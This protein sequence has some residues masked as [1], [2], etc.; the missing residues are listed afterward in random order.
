[1]TFMAGCVASSCGGMRIAMKITYAMRTHQGE[2]QYSEDAVRMA[3]YGKE[4][5]FLLAD[6][7]GGM[8]H[9]EVASEMAVQSAAD[10]F[11]WD[12][13]RENILKNCIE[14]AQNAVR[15]RQ[16]M[17]VELKGMAT[18]FVGLHLSDDHARWIHVGDSRLYYFR[19]GELADRTLDHSVPQLLL[20]VGEISAS[21]IRHHPDRNRLLKIIG[22]EWGNRDNYT[23]AHP[24]V[25]EKGDSFLLCS[26]GLWEWV[27]DT[28][29]EN[30]LQ[31][32]G[33]ALEW[34]S[35]L[36]HMAFVRGYG[37]NMDNYSAICVYVR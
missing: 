9:G 30:L 1:M 7:L 23:Y 16:K 13:D 24:V 14:T 22:N 5:L 15:T 18:T 27:E 31:C 12:P 29:L 33:S 21:D 35:K 20:D 34:L 37:S 11:I 2:R 8:G 28:E 25:L 19:K 17:E 10:R 4:W 6:G 36:E 32:S 26:D 3:R